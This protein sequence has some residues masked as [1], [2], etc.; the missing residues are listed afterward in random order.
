MKN[1]IKKALG[2]A[3]AALLLVSMIMG[4]TSVSANIAH[5]M[6]VNM[7]NVMFYDGSGSHLN[8]FK[9]ELVKAF[10]ACNTFYDYDYLDVFTFSLETK[11]F[12]LNG[13]DAYI[14]KIEG[15]KGVKK[16]DGSTRMEGFT[17]KVPYKDSKGRPT[18]FTTDYNLKT[19]YFI[20]NIYIYV[21]LSDGS[22]KKFE[23]TTASIVQDNLATSRVLFKLPAKYI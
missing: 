12:K 17:F 23:L 20:G 22:V 16:S 4:V 13:K 9:S 1:R 19:D 8:E 11:S 14:S 21:T 5:G 15:K 18:L 7:N 6:D 10:D 3:V 2:A